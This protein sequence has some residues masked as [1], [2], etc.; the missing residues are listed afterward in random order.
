M[1][2]LIYGTEI[3]SRIMAEEMRVLR[4][5]EGKTKEINSIPGMLATMQF[6]IFVFHHLSTHLKIKIHKII[7][8]SLFSTSSQNFVLYRSGRTKLEGVWEKLLSR[9]F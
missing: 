3:F 9:I 2:I 5:M 4:N 6:R 1:P 7:I 8:S